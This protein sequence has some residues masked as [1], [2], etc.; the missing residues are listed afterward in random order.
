MSVPSTSRHVR[1]LWT[2]SPVSH[3]NGRLS[4]VCEVVHNQP[5]TDQS[6]VNYYY[7]YCHRSNPDRN[8]YGRRVR[9]RNLSINPYTSDELT[10]RELF[11]KS[12]NTWYLYKRMYP[13]YVAICRRYYDRQSDYH[14]LAG[15]AIGY[16][17]KY[18]DGNWPDIWRT[19]L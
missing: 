15:Y 8:F 18:T 6:D 4:R 16:M 5:D 17:R 12:C 19:T 11:T 14:T 3:I 2:L 7:G 10:N 9:A 1:Y 13:N